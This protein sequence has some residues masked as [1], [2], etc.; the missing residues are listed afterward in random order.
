M[1]T[2]NRP[3]E[4]AQCN[5]R[6][7]SSKP[8]LVKILARATRMPC[9]KRRAA[10]KESA[11]DSA[12]DAVELLRT[13]NPLSTIY[14]TDPAKL[15]ETLA[16]LKSKEVEEHCTRDDVQTA[17]VDLLS[18]NVVAN[19]PEDLDMLA[20]SLA[21]AVLDEAPRGHKAAAYFILF[22]LNPQAAKALDAGFRSPLDAYQALDEAA[23][24]A[25]MKFLQFKMGLIS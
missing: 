16:K 10:I 8:D 17:I 24:P 5:E 22:L 25:A 6:V 20:V 18:F 3:T 19:S 23:K 11:D 4:K 1:K 12:A 14:R 7:D 2:E 21:N 13:P 9:R 15:T